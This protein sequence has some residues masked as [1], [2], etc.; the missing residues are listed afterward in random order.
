MKNYGIKIDIKEGMEDILKPKPK[1]EIIKAALAIK[2]PNELL[3]V[4]VNRI[5]DPK[6][7]A[8]A[9]EKG[10]DPNTVSSDVSKVDNPEIIRILLTNPHT[11][12]S[13]NHLIFKALKF[14]LENEVLDLIKNNKLD[15]GQKGSIL[16][17]WALGYGKDKIL[18]VLMKDDRVKPEMIKETV[19]E[20][21]SVAIARGN[22]ESVKKLLKDKRVDPSADFNRPIKTAAKFGN[23]KILKLLLK[24][25]RVD[26]SSPIEKDKKD[27][28]SIEAAAENGY[29]DIVKL[30]IQH[31]KVRGKMSN[32]EI[33]KYEDM[34]NKIVRE[35]L[36]EQQMEPI[37][38]PR[39][40]EPTTKPRVKPGVKPTT[41][42]G[43][44]T[45]IRRTRPS[46]IPKPKAS[47]EDV[48]KKFLALVS[49]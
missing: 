12:I 24:D 30:L 8:I 35:S 9:I 10:A 1:E 36:I 45:P 48:A 14:G 17:V 22:N 4:A 3:N 49:K 18:D 27:N 20:A 34:A 29:H 38:K 33:K 37:T 13:P 19:A 28:Y 2:D 47:A 31:P 6:I 26:P 15:P 25:K 16:L 41:R 11:N 21:L 43:A 44:P 46:V 32:T 39:V 40:A 23:I 42:P 7:V 5:K